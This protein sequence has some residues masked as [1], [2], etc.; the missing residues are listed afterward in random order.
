MLTGPIPTKMG[1]FE[2]FLGPVWAL[3]WGAKIEGKT[4]VLGEITSVYR[5]SG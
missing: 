5:I 2:P 4:G 3:L 1:Y